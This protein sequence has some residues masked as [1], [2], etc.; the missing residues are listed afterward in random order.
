MYKDLRQFIKAL[1]ATGDLVRIRAEVDWDEEIGGIIE[2][3]LRRDQPALLFENI[4]DHQRT[5]GRKLLTN[6]QLGLFRRVL[7]AWGLSEN[8]HPL[9][10]LRILKERCRQRVKP[11]VVSKGSCKEVIETGDK[12]NLLEFPSPKWH[13]RDGGRYIHTWGAIVTR[14]PDSGWINAGLQRGQVHGKDRMTIGFIEKSH[15]LMHAAKYL[16]KGGKSMP[17]AVVLGAPPLVPYV[18]CAPFPA[19]VDEFDVVGAIQQEP[20]EVIKCETSDL[21]VP[22]H[23]EIILEGELLLDPSTFIPEGPF[24]EY[25]GTYLGLDKV[26][27]R[28]LQ[29]KCVT[30]RQDP[31]LHGLMEG[32]GPHVSPARDFPYLETIGLWQNL[33]DL[34]IPGIKGVYP[35]DSLGAGHPIIIVSIDNMYYGHARHVATALWSVH[36]KEL[37]SKI[38]IVVDSDVDIT[39]KNAVL[40]AVAQRLRPME[41]ITIF[42]GTIGGALDPSIV[43]EIREMTGGSGRWDRVLIDATWPIE[44]KPRPEW[45]GQK[46]PIYC[47]ASKELLEQVRRRWQ[48]Y[49]LK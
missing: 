17:V 14:D 23:S 25:P 43:P 8:T 45:G 48:E 31:I 49:G 2:E 29:V 11:V 16:A 20:L 28:V 1:E 5:H 36:G 19:G 13:A 18:A 22:A 38:V 21:V 40:N 26:M 15:A 44:W 39:D 35:G 27:R 41:G 24:G 4:K 6:T 47:N 32:L 34:G 37:Q 7:M 33:E 9:E 46:H 3:A 30:H 12:V 10:A 42:P